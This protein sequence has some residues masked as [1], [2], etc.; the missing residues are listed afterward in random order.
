MTVCV[1]VLAFFEVNGLVGACAVR[2][3]RRVERSP[4]A[5]SEQASLQR[6][7]TE[8][9]PVLDVTFRVRDLVTTLTRGLVLSGAAGFSPGPPGVAVSLRVATDVPPFASRHTTIVRSEPAAIAAE[10]ACSGDP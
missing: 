1:P 10:L 7:L 2:E 3:P 5:L 4:V 6:T 8:T 9:L